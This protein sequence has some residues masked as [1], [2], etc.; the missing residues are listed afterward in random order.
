LELPSGTVTLLFTDIEGSTVLA[1]QLDEGWP[2]LLAAHNRLL[3]TAFA[4]HGGT[5]LGTEG[6]AFFVAFTAAGGAAAAAADAQRSLAAHTWPDGGAIRVRMGLHTG[7]PTPTPEGYVGIDMHR[8]ARVAAAGHGGQVLLSQ[9]TRDLLPENLDGL[10]FRDLGDHR[11]KDLTGPQRL[12]QLCGDGLV[13]EFPPPRTI[14]GR[15]TNLPAQPTPL[16][17]RDAELEA[18]RTLL[19][20]EN[21]RMVTLTGP[22]G[23]GKT[24]LALQVAADLVGEF[25]DGVY[26]VL[27]API[28]D[29]D[30][31]PIELARMLGV[32][33]SSSLSVTEALK[34]ELRNRRVLIVFDNFEHV[35]AA[36]EL[37]A[38]LL[39]ACQRLKML[40]TSRE[41]LRIAAERQF[42]VPPLGLPASAG[43]KTAAE[44][45]QSDAVMLF[46]ERARALRPDFELTDATAPIVAE[47]C[48]RLD[49]LPLAIE[50]AAAWTKVLPP[51]SLLRRLENRLELP[52]AR[53]R[54]VPARQS[55]LRQAIAW[56]Y[57]LLG[58]EERRLHPRLSVFMGGFTLETAERV[59]GAGELDVLEGIASLVDR[60]LLRE[61][62]EAGG[63]PRFSMLETI[64]EFAREQLAQAV[65]E[66]QLLNR[67]ALEFA[68]FAE[69]ADAGLRG[70]DQLL[71][72]ERLEAEHDNLRAALDSSLAAGNAETAL[73]LGGA[74]GWFWYTHGHGMEGCNRLTEL[75]AAT[76]GAPEEL[77]ARPLYALGVLVDQR[78]E[79]QR[80]AELVERSL[81]SFREQDD[82]ERVGAALNSLGSIKRALGDLD[83]ARSL[84]EE[85]LAIRRQLGDEARAASSLGNLGIL[86]FERGDLDDAESRF[87]EAL[88]LDRMHGNEWGAS[89]TLDSLVAVAIERGDH[90]RARELNREMLSSAQ[91]VRDQELIAF[92]L[93]K[94]AILAAAERQAARAGRLA[95][96]S[97]AVRE[98]A[99]IDRSDFDRAW[100]DRQLGQVAGDEFEACRATGKAIEPDEALREALEG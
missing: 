35:G 88:E 96:A 63:E 49:G 4:A 61:A 18:V 11:L 53:G 32:E 46:V 13:D 38:A 62:E 24:R 59:A 93:E 45:A 91:R 22:G 10:T 47:I 37:L 55:T 54:E 94:A 75:L 9:T 99:G 90:E 83:A 87:L 7:A 98:A 69:E 5:E 23:T 72:F 27:L 2:A 97:D 30:L 17:G 40:V 68:Q 60:S 16:V 66:D 41:P 58:E 21:T 92:G 89:A 14:E 67:H 43:V 73:R 20:D 39:G 76:E 29:P 26:G 42:P 44:A 56:S 100:L 80:A 12:Y 8:A 33:E 19:L 77:R 36:A 85:S 34:G 48:E 79:P 84:L 52:A 74:L 1:E 57:D 3:R 15:V 71:W 78:G 51:A 25:P 95:G 86:A 50:L 64:R 6:D 31:V 81:A 65:E 70:D 28:S 82:R